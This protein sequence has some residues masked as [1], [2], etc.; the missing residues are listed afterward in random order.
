[1]REGTERL[2]NLPQITQHI[3]DRVGS[4]PASKVF[5]S[6]RIP[7]VGGLGAVSWTLTPFLSLVLGFALSRFQKTDSWASH[8]GLDRG[9]LPQNRLSLRVGSEEVECWLGL[10]TSAGPPLGEGSPHNHG[11]VWLACGKED[12]SKEELE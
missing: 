12:Q 8:S 7:D 3:R 1:M 6:K 4:T 11:G 10:E 2:H 9:P 5:P